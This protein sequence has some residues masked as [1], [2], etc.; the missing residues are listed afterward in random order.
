M[1]TPIVGSSVRVL[2]N[3]RSTALRGLVGKVVAVG[4]QF[5]VNFASL[6]ADAKGPLRKLNRNEVVPV[7][8]CGAP[9]PASTPEPAA[10]PP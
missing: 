7:E 4:R 1:S 2:D 6:E 8:E 3:A 9:A 10:P 5:E